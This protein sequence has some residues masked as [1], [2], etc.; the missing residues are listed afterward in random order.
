[1]HS[2]FREGTV[3]G[4]DLLTV[5]THELGHLIGHDEI[6]G[7]SQDIMGIALPLGTRRLA[8]KAAAPGVDGSMAAS[9]LSDPV[10]SRPWVDQQQSTATA[11]FGSIVGDDLPRR[12]LPGRRRELFSRA[13]DLCI[14]EEYHADS[15]SL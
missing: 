15:G 10:L 2:E 5:L 3:H 11:A 14:A 7:D 1:D 6:F 13:T 9:R 12:N 4:T 8:H